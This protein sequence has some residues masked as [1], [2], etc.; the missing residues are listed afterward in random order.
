VYFVQSIWV[1]NRM[2]NTV[3][4]K[5][6]VSLLRFRAPLAARAMPPAQTAL[7]VHEAQGP[8]GHAR[9]LLARAQR[10]L[11]FAVVTHHPGSREG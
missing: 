4:K 7:T 1:F 5:L 10:M 2:D 11:G 3:T 9:Y 8:H 6:S